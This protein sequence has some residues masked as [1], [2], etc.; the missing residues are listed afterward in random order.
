[1]QA[2]TIFISEGE[3]RQIHQASLSILA[4]T[5]VRIGSERICAL[6]KSKGALVEGSFVRF[7]PE[8]ISEYLGAVPS[9]LLLAA[10]DL[11]HD[12]A[13]PEPGRCFQATSGFS[14]SVMDMETNRLRKATEAD[15]VEIALL[16]DY[17]EMVDLFWPLVMPTDCHP[18]LEELVSLKT[19]FC[20][21]GK[22]VQCSCS[23]EGVARWM[24]RMGEAVAGD[25]AKLRKRPVFSGS[26]SPISPLYFDKY[27]VEA[28]AVLAEAGVPV[29][30]MTM[31]STGT[32]APVT[33]AGSLALVHA[34]EL[35]AFLLVKAVNP[36]VPFIYAAD[37]PPADM[38][39]GIVDYSSP[40]YILLCTGL[41][42]LAS[43]LGIPSMVSHASIEAIPVDE[44]S[45]QRNILYAS[46]GMMAGSDVSCW[47][48][49]FDNALG[50]SLIH[51]LKDAETCLQA[52]A[53]VRRFEVS[54][55]TL[56]LEAIDRIGPGGHFLADL[57]TLENL[58]R[59]MW[60]RKW[61]E[62]FLVEW[63]EGEAYRE[64]LKRKVK[65]ILAN[66]QPVALGAALRCELDKLL[67]A[68][69]D[70]LVQ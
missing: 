62:G 49:T 31:A 16:A 42:Q 55:E 15:L 12:I 56:A 20:F 13:L 65:E 54:D 1:M 19:A 53:Y 21:T 35:A 11:T 33:L 17:L 50:G 40:E 10:R 14:S 36:A 57:H 61:T 34:E 58:H 3:I 25:K 67:V 27:S 18:R 70:D 39:S 63:D 23:G 48:G 69:T 37:V 47:M 44:A 8:M 32:K 52:K 24:V 29:A 51:L 45:L 30:P 4:K 38:R 2:K 28:M 60:S 22:H 6:L 46:W 41:A 64:N 59:D 9:S 66:H 68:A 7:P 43:Y 26:F 5:G